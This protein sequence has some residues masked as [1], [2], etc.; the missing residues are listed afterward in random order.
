MINWSQ[1]LF[2]FVAHLPALVE[3]FVPYKIGLDTLEKDSTPPQTPPDWDQDLS[4]DSLLS[5]YRRG[6]SPVTVMEQV[7]KNIESYSKKDPAVRFDFFNYLCYSQQLYILFFI[8][9]H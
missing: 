2:G 8:H 7:Y 4:I 5:A 9:V 1:G 3:A 6:L